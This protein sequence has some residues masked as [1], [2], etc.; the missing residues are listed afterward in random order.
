[1][2]KKLNT[3][4]AAVSKTHRRKTLWQNF[5]R[6]MAMVVIFCTTYALI[7]P[8]ITMEPDLI[9][10]LAEHTHTEGCWETSLEKELVCTVSDVETETHQHEEAC[11]TQLELTCT[12][13]E[14]ETETHQ[15]GETCW[16]EGTLVCTIAETEP[17]QHEEA[18][19]SEPELVCT[20]GDVETETHQHDETC[21][22]E[23]EVT[24]L[25][26]TMPEHTHEDAC[27]AQETEGE[28]GITYTCG[29][30]VHTHSEACY[31][32]S[33]NLICTIPEHTHQAACAASTVDPAADLESAADWEVMI[34]QLEF[35]GSWREDLLTVAQSQTG[36]AE[37]TVN[38]VLEGDRLN[39]YTRYGDWYG[40]PYM[41][42]DD[43]F[44]AFCLH[45]AGIPEDAIPRDS[46][47]DTWLANLV[48]KGLTHGTADSLPQPGDI[49]FFKKAD[50]KFHTA[51]VENA[52]SADLETLQFRVIAGD[53]N[54]RVEKT[55]ITL[56]SIAAVCDPD[57]ARE[58]L[59]APQTTE[60][61]AT[62]PDA[63]E[64]EAETVV[65]TAE[66]ENYIVTVSHPASLTL[67]EGAQLRVTEYPKDSE[68]YILRCQEAGYELEWL[69]NIG[70]FL[71][72]DE[73][74]LS[75]GFD[76]VVTSKQGDTLGQDITHFA[77]SGTE[78]IDADSGGGSVSFTSGGFSDFG[79]GIALLAVAA[80]DNYQLV[81]DDPT[82]LKTGVDYVIYCP[83]DTNGDGKADNIVFLN[84]SL[85]ATTVQ[86]DAEAFTKGGSWGLAASEI[87]SASIIWRIEK[88]GDNTYLTINGQRLTLHN[89]WLQL[90][91]GGTALHFNAQGAGA[92][93]G[94]TY[95]L[96]Y[97][98]QWRATY[99][100]GWYWTQPT[101]VY[102]ASIYDLNTNYPHAVH[103]G[104][105]NI[106]RLRFYNLCENGDAGVGP[107]AGCVFEITGANG[108]K[109]T[110]VSGDDPEL[111]LPGD[112]P[113]GEYTITEVS[114]PAGY[115]RDKEYTRTF[116]V[117]DGALVSDRTIGTFLNHN[118]EQLETSKTAEVEDYANRIYQ[119]DMTAKSNMRHFEVEPVDLLFVVDQ[120]NSMLFP[121]GLVDT[122][123]KVTLQKNGTNNVA[124]INALNLD[125]SQ[126]YYIIADPKGTSTVWAVWHDGE[127]WLCQD[128]SYY[129]KAKHANEV[130]YQD[131]N[132]TVI[133]PDN[134]SYSDQSK[135]EADNVRSNGAGLG[136]D[137]TGS[138][139]GT[140][141]EKRGNTDTFTIYTA[142][143]EFNRLHYL[144][145][146]LTNLIYQLADISTLNRASL[147]RFTKV[148]DSSKDCFGPY[149]LTPDNAETLAYQVQHIKTSGGTRQDI[150][151][152]H[153]YEQH[154]SNSGEHYHD[155][156]HTYTLLITDG[157]PVYNSGTGPTGLGSADDAANTNSSTVY[158][159]IKG[160]AAEVREE[161]T[162]LTVA[163]G[164]ESVD[165]G[166]Q[167]LKEIASGENNYCAA[168]DA[169][170]LLDFVQSLLFKNFRPGDYIE[171]KG[172]IVDEISNSFY[173]IA[174]VEKGQG[175]ATGRKVLSSDATRDWVLLEEND[176]ITLDGK[177]TTPGAS[178]AKGRLLRKT[179]GTF[180]VQWTDQIVSGSGWSGRFYV[181][182]KEDFIGGNAID[183]NKEA[184]VT[185]DGSKETLDTPTVNVRLLDMNEMSSEVTI[186]LGEQV[187]GG[188]SY[189]MTSLMEFYQNTKFTKLISDE[190]NVLNKITID[191]VKG[192]E[193][194][195]FYLRYAMG[196]DLTEEQWTRLA[197]GNSVTVPYTYDDAS[198]HGPVGCFTFKLEK[199]GTGSHYYQHE[200]LTA[201]QPGGTPLT[202]NCSSPVETYTLNVTY[203]AYRLGQNGRPTGNVHNGTEGPGTEVGTGTTLPTGQGTVQKKNVHEVHVIS[204]KIEVI[205]K[206][207]E[208]IT[209]DQPQTFT[210]TLHP[211][212]MG[213][214]T[215]K[216]VTKTITIPAGASAGSASIVFDGLRRGSYTV[217]EAVDEDYA[218]KGITVLNSTNSYTE[219][220]IGGTD[221]KLLATMGNNVGNENVIGLANPADRYTSYIDPVNGVYAA[222]EF[223]NGPIVYPAE[224]PVE[225][226]WLDGDTD[227]SGDTVYVALYLNDTPVI[228]GDGNARL[229]RLDA[230]SGWKGT[231]TVYLADENDS[232]ENYNYS[233]REISQITTDSSKGWNQ[234]ILENDGS[235]LY[236]EQALKEGSLFL[237]NGRSYVVAYG[238]GD[239]GQLT[240]TNYWATILPQTGG[241]GTHLYTISGLLLLM[242]AALIYGYSQRRKTEGG[243]SR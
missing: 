243:A 162:L 87:G 189:P 178:D 116:E 45:Y 103:T 129:A 198:S 1:M 64:P 200:A 152:Q 224:I 169:A 217:T 69:L 88:S 196:E 99:N 75:G 29:F 165:A 39:G 172:D 113:D 77:D 148:V 134:L 14:V 50:G 92:H 202:E 174:W 23:K 183:T 4:E 212:A 71:G 76:V 36:Y 34:A 119:I 173:P 61:E 101:T 67:P 120:S 166:K 226:L 137:L 199:T 38:C 211:V 158:G 63:T 27:Y 2:R 95:E 207:A 15:H 150:A 59:N 54:N 115:V 164:M 100:E 151:L 181:K 65:H 73:L 32:E 160:W 49:V 42:W 16:A 128:A 22:V 193:A 25:T 12:I 3:T 227:H 143:N 114:A 141:L 146:A 140:Y 104:T 31:D 155:L 110:V 58:M 94:G 233:I 46:D 21:W 187:N 51:I 52:E 180:Y 108:Y 79:G 30:T 117:K 123:K 118:M 156:N 6:T 239:S 210:F 60:P 221:T 232:L 122:G 53:L 83:V 106:D 72:E 236:Y 204:G 223:T 170:Q 121:S 131:D 176:C 190:G 222:A 11:W 215:S 167:V 197:D 242:A 126:V 80:G 142:T 171:Y 208:G 98:D 157:A 40:N 20:I 66:T 205:K 163:L 235:T 97:D 219:P 102:F 84:S 41:A 209:D 96:R 234:A 44:I 213:P 55:L 13:A 175:A 19:W 43:A 86:A 130:G 135:K 24:K 195:E 82:K 192:L 220:G 240:V 28:A 78:R 225:K 109:A 230:A 191:S 132:E 218:L 68:T 35:T 70:F 154:L 144:E 216:D 17:H 139:L 185:V 7:L 182:A 8:A 18:C 81:T 149:N 47:T 238:T 37:S 93:V 107:L 111:H 229:L 124:N 133:F 168:D 105:V 136:K 161:S 237:I 194:A 203:T 184:S 85:S 10:T 145:E 48:Q 153:V 5:V 74:T 228:D 26:C 159:R 201:C 91:N 90:T 206:F 231:F 89:G 33:G 127:N 138:S 214:D 57:R 241:M 147:T 9:C 62:E 179:D 177:L 112:I 188:D 186:Y 125:K 56:D